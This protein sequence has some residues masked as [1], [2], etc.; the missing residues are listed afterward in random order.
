[1]EKEELTNRVLLFT[2]ADSPVSH[3]SENKQM[4]GS[5]DAKNLEYFLLGD[6]NVD[7]CIT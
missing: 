2:L 1:M 5:M 6:I 3:F 7:S 4:I